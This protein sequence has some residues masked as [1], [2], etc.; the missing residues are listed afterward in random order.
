MQSGELVALAGLCISIIVNL[1]SIGVFIGQMKGFKEMVEF[2][3]K[4]LETKQDKYNHLQE[5]LAVLERDNKTAF[6][7]ID[8]LGGRN[9]G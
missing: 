4:Q 6:K 2:R 7:L 3:F 1:V 9:N 5:R 8:Q